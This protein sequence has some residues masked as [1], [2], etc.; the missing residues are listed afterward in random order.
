MLLDCSRYS[1]VITAWLLHHQYPAKMVKFL[2]DFVKEV[3]TYAIEKARACNI[4][5]CTCITGSP[6]P[7]YQTGI[8]ID[9]WLAIVMLPCTGYFTAIRQ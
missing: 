7:S 8:I 3:D 9:Y 1:P 6:M 2:K 5:L 4:S